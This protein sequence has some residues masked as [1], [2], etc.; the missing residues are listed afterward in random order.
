MASQQQSSSKSAGVTP[1]GV[2]KFSLLSQV[3]RN[4][5]TFKHQLEPGWTFI[6]R[7]DLISRLSKDFFS[8]SL[9]L[10]GQSEHVSLGSIVSRKELLE[11]ISCFPPPSKKEQKTGRKLLQIPVFFLESRPFVSGESYH[12]NCSYNV[13][14]STRQMLKEYEWCENFH[15]VTEHHHPDGL[16][17]NS[18]IIPS[19][20]CTID[21]FNS[22][23]RSFALETAWRKL[24]VILSGDKFS[25]LDIDGMYYALIHCLRR[26]IAN[27]DYLRETARWR[28]RPEEELQCNHFD[29]VKGFAPPYLISAYRKE[30][31]IH[32]ITV[33]SE[34]RRFRAPRIGS[35][36]I[37]DWTKFDPK[38]EFYYT[39]HWGV[40]QQMT[41]VMRERALAGMDRLCPVPH[42]VFNENQQ[43]FPTMMTMGRRFAQ[44][45]LEESNLFTFGRELSDSI[46]KKME[47]VA[48]DFK[49]TLKEER[50]G[51]TLDAKVLLE[52][53]T[54]AISS[55]SDDLLQKAVESSHLLMDRAASSIEP[56]SQSLELLSGTVSSVVST[57]ANLFKGTGIE[58]IKINPLTI[59]EALKYYVVYV[60]S[61]STV[62][63]S[64]CVVLVLHTFGFLSACYGWIVQFYHWLCPTASGPGIDETPAQETSS[65]F[66][67]FSTTPTSM[68][69]VLS[70][71]FASMFKGSQLLKEEFW[72]LI[73][74]MSNN[75]RDFHFIG[76]GL[77][78]LTKI[79][80]FSMKAFSTVITWCRSTFLGQTSQAVQYARRVS[81]LVIKTR[82]LSSEAGVNAIRASRAIRDQAGRLLPE[83][84]TLSEELRHKRE[85]RP[86]VID[87][88]RISRQVKEV[89]DLVT[90]LKNMSDFQPTMF[91][92][93]LVGRPGIGKSTLTKNLAHSLCRTLWPRDVDAQI[94]SWN[95]SLDYFD[96]YAGQ[97]IMLADDLFRIN[98]PQHLTNLIGLITN[99]PVILP[100]ANLTDKGIQLTSQMLI[101]STNT[102]YPV[103]KDILCTEALLR[104]RHLLVEVFM[105]PAV[106]DP[107][108]GQFSAALFKSAYPGKNSEDFPHLRFNLL[109]P[110]PDHSGCGLNSLKEGAD[111]FSLYQSYAKKLTENNVRILSA[112]SNSVQSLDPEFYFSEDSRPPDGIK[113]PCTGWSYEQFLSN[114]VV[115]FNAFRG[116]E[117]TYTSRQRYEHA[118]DCL[119]EVDSLIDQQDDWE[120]GV[121]FPITK[122][123]EQCLYD[124]QF[125]FGS[126]DPL[127]KRVA[128]GIAVAPELDSI[129]LDAIVDSIVDDSRPT[130]DDIEYPSTSSGSSIESLLEESET[131]RRRRILRQRGKQV[132]C[133]ARD[134]FNPAVEIGGKHYLRVR[135]DTT[136]LEIYP[137]VGVE[138]GE[139]E[140]YTARQKRFFEVL[141][142]IKVMHL[143]KHEREWD[144]WCTLGMPQLR[145]E[146]LKINRGDE[147][148][149][150]S[151]LCSVLMARHGLVTEHQLK[152]FFWNWTL[153]A[154]A[155][156]P[157][158]PLF[159]EEDRGEDF[160]FPLVFLQNLHKID[161]DWYLDIEWLWAE[162]RT[163]RY[164]TVKTAA[165]D[166]PDVKLDVQLDPGLLFTHL[167]TWR[168]FTREFENLTVAQQDVLVQDAKWRSLYFGTYSY[169]GIASQCRGYFDTAAYT[170]LSYLVAPFKFMAE[171]YP[172]VTLMV[173]VFLVYLTTIFLL[174]KI[175]EVVNP[176][177]VGEETSKYLHRGP[178]KSNIVYRG[179]FTSADATIP[180]K[181]LPET[182]LERN[183]R[184]ISVSG[185]RG[186]AVCQGLLSQQF[187]LINK[188]VMRQIPDSTFFLSISLPGQADA[189]LRYILDRKAYWEDPDGDLAIIWDQRLPAVKKLD[190]SFV[191][192]SELT[193]EE[194]PSALVFLSQHQGVPSMEHHSDP[195]RADGLVLRAHDREMSMR[196]GLLVSGSTFVGKSGSTVLA[197]DPQTRGKIL[198]LQAWQLG[199]TC[200]PQIA[201]QLV[202]EEKFAFMKDQVLKQCSVQ[203]I[204][205]LAEPESTVVDSSLL[206]AF[207]SKEFNQVYS[208]S[209]KTVGMVGKT[210]FAKSLIAP[211]ME[212]SGYQSQRC[213]AALNPH[214]PRLF[215]QGQIHPMRSSL[216]K[217][218]KDTVEPFVPSLLSY[219]S[220]AIR[221]QI[222]SRLDKTSFRYLGLEEV[223][224]GIREDGSNPMNLSSSPG[225]PFVFEQRTRKGKKD[226]LEVDEEG[227]LSFADPEFVSGYQK[228]RSTLFEGKLPGTL[229]YD[230]PKDELRPIGKALGTEVSPPKTRS[231]TCMNVYYVMLWRELTL[232]FWAAMHR[233]ANGSFPFCPGINPE[234]PE[235]STAYHYLNK[236]SN[237]VDFDVS[238]WDG[239]LPSDLFNEAIE[240]VL[241]FVAPDKTSKEAL[242]IRAVALEV[243]NC[244]I[245]FG[246]LIYQKH[247]GMVSGFP[248]TAEINSLSHWL[249]VFYIYMLLTQHSMELHSLQ[250]FTE[251]VSVLVYGDD[252]IITFS[253]SVKDVF[254]GVEISM[255]Y[256]AIGYPVTSASKSSDIKASVPLSEC[257]FLKSGWRELMP[258]YYI[259][260][261]DISIA[262]DLIY[263][264]RS[265]QG[266]Y[267]QFMQNAIDALHIAF[268][269]GRIKFNEF[270]L[271]LNTCLK[272]SKLP[273]V[274]FT[275]D[276]LLADYLRRYLSGE[277]LSRFRIDGYE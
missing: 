209:D 213:P 65:I 57:F 167:L 64:L 172:D 211:V 250:A 264:V 258:M 93:Q 69:Q 140:E 63:K 142:A 127:G 102:P 77:T 244:Y 49:D 43:N 237:A 121:S 36:A 89:A 164:V 39:W 72:S 71:L 207:T 145:D 124:A 242:A 10:Y 29:F 44:G 25:N 263:W 24:L 110:V 132:R 156:V 204:E 34:M 91:H 268:G 15:K 161:G 117:S 165:K 253:D 170:C 152:R 178:Q 45:A 222:A 67:W 84:T 201:V 187:L 236:H 66:E 198:G 203:P 199:A 200:D 90:R 125:P 88:E 173:A 214:D 150:D 174:R 58:G 157:D 260:V 218:F 31:K 197:V 128:E 75:M 48:S 245:Q 184:E 252:V 120:K 95:P 12:G 73:K 182:V 181:T 3:H 169:E 133:P 146:F 56:I 185:S 109:K 21:V 8:Q 166:R 123:V 13:G 196:E 134:N 113:L 217:Y 251:N 229:A 54:K 70:A 47:Q 119:L 221:Q 74:A 111:A 186:G 241:H 162:D 232:D 188:H 202:T 228:F 210:Q 118:E 249:L 271:F 215:H 105:D 168:M 1:R 261:L 126:E 179:A 231:V 52:D 5:C 255:I 4:L 53:F 180:Q 270:V 136:M 226:Y 83:W 163:H 62:L 116:M 224:V 230:F 234:G 160:G 18:G 115:R 267:T 275:Y 97:K 14:G 153:G 247:R 122:L 206:D 272:K 32:Q 104:R 2:R 151:F 239:F 225:I 41:P 257:Q 240:I 238:N 131:E 50:R 107:S 135:S 227:F 183:V 277:S 101:S 38:M 103:G 177:P 219:C 80:D 139:Y 191:K 195:R 114:C 96:G 51:A 259:R 256:K 154:N 26:G 276:D 233:A 194:L 46:E 59:L 144:E 108:S 6:P 28:N 273:P 82:F 149:L 55:K 92:V 35:R 175:A 248:G 16:G 205:R 143:P 158:N 7:K 137:E 216:G 40:Y 86:L 266:P 243:M 94:Y 85:F 60:N 112:K 20:E 235:W 171:K 81:K 37:H 262:Y 212:Q 265:K 138:P 33:E 193:S 129:D 61:T 189:A 87:L 98:E 274:L 130:S 190:G 254:N 159:P 23:L 68:V 11:Y 30:T 155:V 176:R 246:N 106:L 76:S 22:L 9:P 42:L 27:T 192:Q 148:Y 79:Y 147:S 208:Q 223:V 220:N 269:H 99:T 17:W 141:A 78:G 19:F 100:M